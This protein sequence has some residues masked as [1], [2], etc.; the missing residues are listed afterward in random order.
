MAAYTDTPAVTGEHHHH[1]DAG[2]A[3]GNSFGAIIA[4]VLLVLMAIIF[5][6]YGTR[7]LNN[8]RTQD[9]TIN[10]PSINVPDKIDVNLNQ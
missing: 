10:A 1:H 6:F 7:F 2:G 4:I 8:A 3:T 9:P 5:L